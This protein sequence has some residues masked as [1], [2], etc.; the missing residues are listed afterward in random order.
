MNLNI[1][2]ICGRLTKQP[3]LKVTKNGKNVLAFSVATNY[4]YKDASGNPVEET[5]FHNVVAWQRAAEVIAQYFNKGDEIYVS[6]RMKT[7]S[8]EDKDGVK[9]YISEIMLEKF[10]F[11][12]KK[13][14]GKYSQGK[15][16]DDGEQG[17]FKVPGEEGFEKADDEIKV[18]D[19]PM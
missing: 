17:G 11:G 10:E 6:G 1:I 13:K 4:K 14:D 19:I 3:E 5:E 7:R 8:W 18:E 2:Q 16:H 15:S 12:Q 9:K